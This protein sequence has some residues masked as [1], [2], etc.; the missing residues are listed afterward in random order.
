MVLWS[1]TGEG[2]APSQCKAVASLYG[3]ENSDGTDWEGAW[4]ELLEVVVGKERK[5][6]S[7]EGACV[8]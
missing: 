5:Q 2:R 8:A 4:S 3:E 1:G 6:Y 7:E